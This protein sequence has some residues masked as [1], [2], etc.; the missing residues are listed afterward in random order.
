M[1][2]LLGIFGGGVPP[3]SPNFRPLNFF[4][5]FYS[6]FQPGYF[7]GLKANFEVKTCWLRPHLGTLPSSFQ[8]TNSSQV[9]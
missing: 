3:G 4:F 6:R 8:L 9:V 5:F 2:L 1:G 7:S